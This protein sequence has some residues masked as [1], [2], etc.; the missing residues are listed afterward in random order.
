[1]RE[2]TKAKFKKSSYRK[3]DSLLAEFDQV[4]VCGVGGQA[5]NVEVGPGERIARAAGGRGGDHVTPR[6]EGRSRVA[7]PAPYP[8][9]PGLHGRDHLLAHH[10]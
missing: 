6:V 7:V 5:A 9:L 10:S 3:N 8:G 4:H 2:G 1:M